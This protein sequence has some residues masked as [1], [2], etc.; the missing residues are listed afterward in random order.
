MILPPNGSASIFAFN[1]CAIA[2]AT[3]YSCS[4]AVQTQ[5]N[6]NQQIMIEKRPL[7]MVDN[8]LHCQITDFSITGNERKQL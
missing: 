8:G 3:A 5:L 2:V 6:K 4:F 1:L 7:F